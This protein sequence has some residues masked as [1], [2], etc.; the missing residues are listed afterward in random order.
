MSVATK[1]RQMERQKKRRAQ[2]R[3]AHRRLANGGL[4]GADA[5]GASPRDT[6]LPRPSLHVPA[7]E[8][9]EAWNR[10]R[11]HIAQLAESRGEYGGYP[12]PDSDK[13]LVLEP[14]FPLTSLQGAKTGSDEPSQTQMD[15]AAKLFDFSR[16]TIHLV[17]GWYSR[18]LEAMVYIY[19]RDGEQSVRSAVEYRESRMDA[20]AARTIVTM[21]C[22]R[23]WSVEAE[24]K[25]LAKLRSLVS[26]TAYRYYV[27]TGA[28]METSRRS[29]VIYV[30]Q[31]CRPTMA[32][33]HRPDGRLHVLASLCGHPIGYYEDSYAG[34]MVPTDDVVSHVLLMRGDEH[35][36]WR[37]CNQHV[38][39]CRFRLRRWDE[40]H[41]PVRREQEAVV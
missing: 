12:L 14:R 24:E 32:I 9:D 40:G 7:G 39:D 36:F 11:R 5:S 15:S 1:T 26:P 8:H 21:G 31:R 34:A 28:F 3:K 23:N 19:R 6:P 22:S 37:K 13:R 35:L 18:R 16:G 10:I 17:N 25:A 38:A 33:R 20:E 27:L 4:L 41:A 29:G 2:L 30:F